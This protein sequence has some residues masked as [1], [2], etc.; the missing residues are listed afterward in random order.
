MEF[1]FVSHHCLQQ[2]QNHTSPASMFSLRF[3]PIL[4]SMFS[5]GITLSSSSPLCPIHYTHSNTLEGVGFM[6]QKHP[7]HST[8]NYKFLESK[9]L[10][11]CQTKIHT[12]TNKIQG[13]V[14]IVFITL[15][16]SGVHSSFW[17]F[18]TRKQATSTLLSIVASQEFSNM[19]QATILNK[20]RVF[21]HEAMSSK[22]M[23]ICY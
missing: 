5:L 12:Y 21:L 4:G 9:S 14:L 23:C 3:C 13:F 20:S 15:T 11:I 6:F 16:T 2:T 22:H 18:L 10:S 1:P 17:F 8:K 7:S 19:I